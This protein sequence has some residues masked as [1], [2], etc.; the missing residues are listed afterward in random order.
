MKRVKI[1]GTIILLQA[2]F[3]SCKKGY[4]V[5]VPNVTVNDTA[6][7]TSGVLK[8]NLVK[9]FEEL[10]GK[11]LESEITDIALGDTIEFANGVRILIP[12]KT[13]NGA[14]GTTAF[15]PAKIQLIFLTSKG[16]FIKHVKPT[17][18]SNN[19][20]DASSEFLVR[21]LQDGKDLSIIQGRY[22]VISYHENAPRTTN[23]V[24]YGEIPVSTSN[25]YVNWLVSSDGSLAAVFVK[26]NPVNPNQTLTGYE[27][28]FKQL[29]W[30]NCGISLDTLVAR[31]KVTAT[32][33][34]IYTN[35]NTRVFMVYKDSK[36]VVQLKDD[37]A[38][39]IFYAVNTPLSKSVMLVS[40]SSINA[41]YYLG[42]ADASV[43]AGLNVSIKPQKKSY[44]EIADFLNKL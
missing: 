42:V 29:R 8:E 25:T 23:K 38:S 41:D 37:V 21:I 20:L 31:S 5:F 12:E 10:A 34:N 2:M 18:A 35:A 28:K 33:P 13:C 4:D 3:F 19:P 27:V 16:Q 11:P 1:I 39:K 24:Y 7:V 9:L 30:V 6:W 26:P 14:N 40:I 43:A 15:G 17:T 44:A 22:I 32:L 36:T